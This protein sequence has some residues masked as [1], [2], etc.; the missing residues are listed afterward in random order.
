MDFTS[1]VIDYG[2]KEVNVSGVFSVERISQGMVRV[3]YY[4]CRNGEKIAK[5]YLV[6]DYHQ[7][8]RQ[9]RFWQEANTDLVNYF[10]AWEHGVDAKPSTNREVN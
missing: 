8:L 5:I 9:W 3:G 10:E 7:W 4:V 2:A 1:N 6:W